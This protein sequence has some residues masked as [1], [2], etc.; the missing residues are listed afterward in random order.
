MAK[1]QPFVIPAGV[2][3]AITENSISI[4]H[5]GDIILHDSLGKDVTNVVS[6]E[7][8]ITLRGRFKVAYL[9]ALTGTIRLE[10]SVFAERVEGDVVEI[11]GR[12]FQTRSVRGGKQ[13]VVGPTNITADIL[14]APHIDINPKATGRVPVIES[15][16]TLGATAIKGGFSVEEYDELIGDSSTFLAERGL[17]AL[18][19]SPDG[20]SADEEEDEDDEEP[21]DFVIEAHSADEEHTVSVEAVEEEWEEGVEDP[22]T[23]P[24][25]AVPLAEHSEAVDELEEETLFDGISQEE[26]R[27]MPAIV[28]IPQDQSKEIE[29]PDVSED[30]EGQQDPLHQRLVEAMAGLDA[31]Y[32]ESQAPPV[33]EELKLLIELSD[34]DQIR[35][36]L[37]HIW[38]EL[39]KYHREKGIRI[40][41][42]V[43]TTFNNVM[44]LV[45]TSS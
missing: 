21:S 11:V 17:T 9:Q 27:P 29:E 38:N 22:D 12:K 13:I 4:E 25:S 32:E 10:G 45:K 34:Y 16:N 7:G 26:A 33:L 2:E 19:P 42:Q 40:R 20:G 30:E 15:H 44:S 5:R 31:C 3:F 23:H 24:G 6:H 36:K 41:R 39:V 14:M 43:T 35:K 18:E 1:H 8:S 37:P 28:H